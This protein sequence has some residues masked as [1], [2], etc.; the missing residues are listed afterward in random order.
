M[1]SILGNLIVIVAL[2]VV[3]VLAARS[4]WREHRNGG[5]CSGNCASCHGC[6]SGHT[7]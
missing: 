4:L 1:S 3:V 5:G 7:K 6:H 2:A